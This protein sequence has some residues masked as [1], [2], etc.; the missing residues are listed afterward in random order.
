MLEKEGKEIQKWLGI[1]FLINLQIHEWVLMLGWGTVNDLYLVDIFKPWTL[2]C[3]RRLYEIQ[4]R[5]KTSVLMITT[6]DSGFMICLRR[7]W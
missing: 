3:V 4:P 2:T 1:C 7:H 5:K 6:L